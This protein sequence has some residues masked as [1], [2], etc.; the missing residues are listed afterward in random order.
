MLDDRAKNV[1]RAFG[2]S[3]GYLDVLLV[4]PYNRDSV[5]LKAWEDACASLVPEDDVRS[6][7][8]SPEQFRMVKGDIVALN[9]RNT[10]IPVRPKWKRLLDWL[11]KY[12]QNVA[13]APLK[14]ASLECKDGVTSTERLVLASM[15]DL[16]QR[17][18]GEQWNIVEMPLYA[19]RA[20]LTVHNASWG[21]DI[22]M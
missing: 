10:P 5:N 6:E 22:G 7:T 12:H 3:K 15:F 14:T 17:M 13:P 1:F 20:L 19:M 11:R 18:R 16:V 21:D 9:L 4:V 8:T 2:Q